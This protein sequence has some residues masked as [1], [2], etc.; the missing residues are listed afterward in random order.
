MA[1]KTF[2]SFHYVPD[3]WRV[4]QV[5]N[6]GV[7]EGN[8][9]VSDNDWE[10]I[11]GKGESAIKE[12]IADQ[13]KG[14]SCAVVLVGSATAGRKWINH[15]IVEAWNKKMGVF[16]VSIHNLKDVK[17]N[18]SWKGSNPFSGITINSGTTYLSSVVK[19]YDPPYT[20]STDVY[21]H[22]KTNM[23]KWADEAC[24][25]RAKY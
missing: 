3:C 10:K 17:G 5:R 19:L 18:Q 21:D 25:I 6:A 4:S 15:E 23:A 9:P 24:D 1:R 22:I 12:W 13:M 20:T 8:T 11:T 2:F 7:V 14:R 16:G